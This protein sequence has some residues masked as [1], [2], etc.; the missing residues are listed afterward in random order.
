LLP[1][2][3]LSVLDTKV[4]GPLLVAPAKPLSGEFEEFVQGSGREGVILVSFGTI[5]R[6][7]NEKMLTVLADAFSRV[8]HRVIWE[9][10]RGRVFAYIFFVCLFVFLRRKEGG[11]EGRKEGRKEGGKEGRKEG[12]RKEGR[13]EG[14]KGGRERGRERQIKE[15][16]ER[17]RKKR[18]KEES[19]KSILSVR[20]N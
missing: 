13:K 17:G 20:N 14:R 1:I 11:K 6:N 8:P 9:L 2:V 15:G 3:S 10:D 12:R 16:R 7:I 5:M 4:V 18:R 19:H